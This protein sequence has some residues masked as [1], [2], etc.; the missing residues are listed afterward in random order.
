MCNPSEHFKLRRT[1]HLEGSNG[2]TRDMKLKRVFEKLS[3]LSHRQI[4]PQGVIDEGR[5][6]SLGIFENEDHLHGRVVEVIEGLKEHVGQPFGLHPWAFIFDISTFKQDGKTSPITAVGLV[7]PQADGSAIVRDFVATP[8]GLQP[9]HQFLFRHEAKGTTI[10]ILGK[11]GK[12]E[13]AEDRAAGS[14]YPPAIAMLNTRGCSID[15]KRAPTIVNAKRTRQGKRPI[16]AHYEVDASEYFTALRSGANA[17]ASGGTHASPMPHLRRAHERV[18]ANGKRIWIPTSLINVRSE[19][20][21][22]FV[23]RR[24]AY[25]NDDK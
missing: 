20:D 19:G 17:E 25:R 2:Y 9:T 1:I 22:A 6:F 11:D 18:L 16:P 24:R 3:E 5:I 13:E 7:W 4:L 14:F 21:I 8:R 15:L 10:S 23:E 12:Q